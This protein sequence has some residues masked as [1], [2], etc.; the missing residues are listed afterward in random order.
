M[1]AERTP[2]QEQA[3]EALKAAVERVAAAYFPVQEMRVIEEFIVVVAVAEIE[4]GVLG[5]GTLNLFRDG[6]IPSWK[7]IG[8]IEDAKDNLSR[9][10]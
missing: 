4:G 7:A 6:N 9:R 2:E 10:K 8:L 3:D 5:N 1:A